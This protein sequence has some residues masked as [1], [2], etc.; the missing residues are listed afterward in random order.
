M[1]NDTRRLLVKYRPFF[2][3]SGII[4]GVVMGFLMILVPFT[5]NTIDVF[6]QGKE[7]KIQVDA[8]RERV[9][10]LDNLDELTLEQQLILASSAIPIEKSLPSIFQTMETISNEEEMT[11]NTIGLDSPQ[12]L[13]TQA[14]AMQSMEEKK[15]GVYILP[16]TITVEGAYDK[17]EGFLEKTTK[18]RRFIKAKK[19]TLIVN[20]DG[21]FTSTVG[22]DAFY[23]P[24][25][26]REM[27]QPLTPLVQGE[28][29]LLSIIRDFPDASIVLTTPIDPTNIPQ[30]SDRNPFSF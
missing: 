20:P 5:Q 19:I 8:L 3:P 9:A 2:V 10:I 1:K 4:L 26:S 29:S 18:V 30:N 16:F 21:S 15:L 28:E 6:N 23:I 24:I 22:L 11:L 13:S 25:Q 17:L 7:L 14:A 12:S 27:Q